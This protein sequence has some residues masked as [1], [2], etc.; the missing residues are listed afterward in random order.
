MTRA[1]SC[2]VTSP[3]ASLDRWSLHTGTDPFLRRFTT[4]RSV[5]Q[6]SFSLLF[7]AG[8]AFDEHVRVWITFKRCQ[9][10]M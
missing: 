7:L 4:F 2:G 8:S 3:R 5:P 10:S 1:Q 6:F 9:T